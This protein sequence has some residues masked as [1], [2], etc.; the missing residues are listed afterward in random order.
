[1]GTTPAA[2]PWAEGRAPGQRGRLELIHG[3]TDEQSLTV[4]ELGEHVRRERGRILAKLD[5]RDRVQVAVYAYEHG[6]VRPG[7]SA[8]PKR[9]RPPSGTTGG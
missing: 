4:D 6:I 3:N 7:R 9:A 8:T 5:L 1:M 2:G